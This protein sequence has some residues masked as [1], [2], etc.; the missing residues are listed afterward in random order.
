VG[1]GVEVVEPNVL[2][3]V[4]EAVELALVV[5]D[6]SRDDEVRGE[7]VMVLF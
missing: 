4:E 6:G 2:V 3:D 1:G 5:G 7:R